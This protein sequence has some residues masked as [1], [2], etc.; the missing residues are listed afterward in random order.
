MS[1]QFS[2]L[3]YLKIIRLQNV[4]MA[5]ATVALGYWLGGSFLSLRSLLLLITATIAATAFGNVINDLK[6]IETD[7]IS[8]P[9]R[10]LPQGRIT[11]RAAKIFTALLA[12]IPLGAALAVSPVHAL[13]TL[14]PLALLSVYTRYLKGVPFAGNIVISLL[15]AYA[16]LFGGIGA[17]S[18]DRLLIPAI[19][20]FLL[21]FS[22]ELIKTVQ[23][24][25]GD[26]AQ[27]LKTAA[28]LPE[29]VIKTVV[30]VTIALYLLLLFTPCR[31]GDFGRVYAGVC[32]IGV[33]P[34]QLWWLSLFIRKTWKQRLSAMSSMI[35]LE[36]VVGL[37]AMAADQLFPL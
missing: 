31:F 26:Q 5:G 23:D 37:A 4:L 36:M 24:A 20:A 6:D 32:A 15:V 25:S 19:L 27:G 11:L 33:V 14:V 1:A 8:H 17:P 13:A 30:Y 22:R 21:N 35:K 2:P 9:E 18:F 10:P 16:L 3:P 29:R 28:A 12:A 7:R 34:V